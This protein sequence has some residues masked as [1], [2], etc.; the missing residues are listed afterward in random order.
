[1]LDVPNDLLVFF[2]DDWLMNLTDLFPVD[3]RLVHFSNYILVLLMDHILDMLMNY[4]SVVLMNHLSVVF[5]NDGCILN[6]FHSCG[7]HDLVND[8][9]NL[10]SLDKSLFVVA[11]DCLR[12]LVGSLNHRLGCI[13]LV[14]MHMLVLVLVR[15]TI[16][17]LVVVSAVRFTVNNLYF[18]GLIVSMSMGLSGSA[19]HRH[20]LLVHCLLLLLLLIHELK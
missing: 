16:S 15:W 7:K 14:L 10:V 8:G 5:L 9:G 3:Y 4:V 13:V 6:H 2:V 11:D 1:M 17:V 19:T 18:S 12:L 20:S